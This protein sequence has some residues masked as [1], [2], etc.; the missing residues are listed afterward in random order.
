M[1][2]TS[3]TGRST[4]THRVTSGLPARRRAASLSIAGALASLTLAPTVAH[5]DQLTTEGGGDSVA[6]VRYVF[7]LKAGCDIPASLDA[8]SRRLMAI[9]LCATAQ[10]VPTARAGHGTPITD[11]VGGCGEPTLHQPAVAPG[12]PASAWYPPL[13]C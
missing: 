10:L 1:K 9:Q 8:W 7:A 5:A 11:E 13:S 6:T 4:T 2:H 3:H 12:M